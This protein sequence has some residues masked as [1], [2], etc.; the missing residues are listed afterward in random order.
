VLNEHGPV[1][2]VDN[3]KAHPRPLLKSSIHSKLTSILN[4]VFSGKKAP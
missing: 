4:F 3:I 1:L 2:H